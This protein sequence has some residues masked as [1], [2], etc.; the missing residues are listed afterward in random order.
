MGRD[1]LWNGIEGWLCLVRRRIR[2]RYV[3][4]RVPKEGRGCREEVMF[5][6]M[7]WMYSYVGF[8]WWGGGSSRFMLGLVDRE[9]RWLV[10]DGVMWKGVY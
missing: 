1:M 2:C 5:G 10:V 3:E 4:R 8:G 7:W 6:E 9:I